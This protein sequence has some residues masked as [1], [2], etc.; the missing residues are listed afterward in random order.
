MRE[1]ERASG[2][3]RAFFN[4]DNRASKNL[5]LPQE[6]ARVKGHPIWQSTRNHPASFA[7][8]LIGEKKTAT[9]E[10][11]NR[12]QEKVLGK[13]SADT[14]LAAYNSCRLA[15]EIQVTLPA[16]LITLPETETD[17]PS[18]RSW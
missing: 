10:R 2:E 6:L 12:S 14:F 8:Q 7:D 9:Q 4:V 15:G 1:T 5:A 13:F 3:R 17:F 18:N 11:S 16:V